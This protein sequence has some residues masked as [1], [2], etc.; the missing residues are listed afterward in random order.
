MDHVQLIL[1]AVVILLM[2]GLGAAISIH[3]FKQAARLWRAPA[4][5]VLCQFGVMPLVA[6]CLALLLGVTK[7]QG[8]SMLV[9]G[10]SPGG[11]TSNLFTYYSRGDLPLSIIATTC[12]TLLSLVCMPL[13]LAAYSGPFTDESVHIPFASMVLPLGMVI[14]PVALGMATKH[15][16]STVAIYVEKTASVLGMLFILAALVGGIATNLEVFT[17]SW[18]LWVGAFVLMPVGSGFGYLISY[19]ARLPP[20]ACRTVCLETGLQNSTLALTILAFSFQN[21]DQFKAVSAFP[22]M[23]SLALLIDGSIITLIF[24][25]LSRK[26][27]LVKSESTT[28]NNAKLEKDL[29][30][31]DSA[32]QESNVCGVTAEQ[33]GKEN[34]EGFVSVAI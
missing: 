28:E 31:T 20:R 25:R 17:E 29:E 9:V 11:S 6:F 19:C 13:A 15:Y 33:Q 18:K 10:C 1:G 26:E 24:N 32:S 4:T 34:P 2:L 7:L 5:A 21:S 14:V 12:S 22:L 30:K 16:S 27:D 23:Y 8:L 3:D